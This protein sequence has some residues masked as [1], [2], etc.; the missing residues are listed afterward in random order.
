M[1]EKSIPNLPCLCASVRRAGR[2]L[3][4]IYERAMRPTGLRATQFTLLQALSLAGDIRQRDLGEI[5]GMDSTTLTRTL[6]IMAR[7][8]WISSREGKDRRE[9]WLGLAPAG[10]AQFNRALPYWEKAQA[11]LRRGLGQARWDE[12]MKSANDITSVASKGLEEL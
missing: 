2:M 4:Q 8:G 9:R 12:L 6:E 3:T 1:S 7:K 10:T 11:S 5:L